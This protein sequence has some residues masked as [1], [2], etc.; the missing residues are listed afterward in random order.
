MPPFPHEERTA[1]ELAQG[2]RWVNAFWDGPHVILVGRDASNKAFKKELPA[3]FSCFVRHSDL[4]RVVRTPRGEMTFEQQLRNSQFVRGIRVEGEWTRIRWKSRD[5]A[6]EACRPGGVF[7]QAKIQTYEGD[8][9]PVRRLL[10][11]RDDIV[12]SRPRRCYTDF[13]GDPRGGISALVRGQSRM[14][15]WSLT[16]DHDTRVQGCLQADDDDAEKLL[17][18][19]LW[20]ELLEYDQIC[21]WNGERFDF[22]FL[23][24]RTRRFG[25]AV[26]PRRF[27]WCDQMQVFKRLNISASQSGEEKQSVALRNVAAALQ[28]HGDEALELAKAKFEAKRAWEYWEA[29]GEKRRELLAYNMD[30]G[31]K[32]PA[33]ERVTGYLDLHQTLCEMCSTPFDTRGTHPVRY[34]EGFVLRM[35]RDVGVKFPSKYYD[36]AQ[37]EKEDEE[38]EQRGQFKGAV[39][40]PPTKKGIVKDVHVCDFSGMYPSIMISWNMSPETYAPDVT[41]EESDIGRPAYLMHVPLKKFERPAGYCESPD[42]KAFRVEPMGIVPRVVSEVVAFRKRFTKLEASLPP[43]T[44]EAQE[45]KRKS[46]AGKIFANVIYGV[47][48]CRWSRIHVREVAEAVTQAGVWLL[49]KTIEAASA[50]GYRPIYGD[51]DSLFIQGPSDEE[52]REFIAW[53]NAELFPVELAKLGCRVCKIEIEYEK[54]HEVVIIADAKKRYAGRYAHFKGQVPNEKSKPEIKGF[55]FKRG[56]AS[57]LARRM[58]AEV[59]DLLLGG[60]VTGPRRMEADACCEDPEVFWQLVVG[61]KKRILEEP[62]ELDDVKIAKNLTR[63]ISS[64]TVKP[65][66]DGSA[67]TLD[68]HVRVARELVARGEAVFEGQKVD[69]FVVDG[70]CSPQKVAPAIDYNGECDRY[71]MWE[72]LVFPPTMRVLAPC[73]PGKPWKEL[74]KARP[75]KPRSVAAKK[76]AVQATNEA[77][78]KLFG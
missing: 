43:G 34:V 75:P 20:Y 10:T 21:A 37:V 50:R 44:P 69:Y 78:G 56:D 11:D 29:G 40:L 64:Y 6:R 48:G 5:L 60:G 33:I 9:D 65:K 14:L 46:M 25:I 66:K 7:E 68:A 63:P 70:G 36:E 2:A 74:L 32:M 28:L 8:V 35:A 67:G 47:G 17:L 58:Q 49:R 13:E 23:I 52:F 54:K 59:L 16:D 62:L 22:P 15:C 61:W 73:F 18:E 76:A 12:L 26:E 42:K 53:C 41:L 31:D 77:Q 51:T 27:L 55:E 24:S 19:D 1:G 39:V 72:T 30:D 3:E 38:A 4:Q 45:A 71:Y 57:R